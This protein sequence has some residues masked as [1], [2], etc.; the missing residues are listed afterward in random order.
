MFKALHEYE[1]SLEFDPK[2]SD[3]L[4]ENLDAQSWIETMTKMRQ[5]LTKSLEQAGKTQ[6]K[7]YNAKKTPKTIEGRDEVFLITQNLG[8]L[9]LERS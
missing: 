6:E 5:N 9:H 4:E 7:Y 1:V 3:G 2:L 8:V